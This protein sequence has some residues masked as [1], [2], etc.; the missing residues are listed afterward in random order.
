MTDSVIS[1]MLE[2]PEMLCALSS[3]VTEATDDG[4][5]DLLRLMMKCSCLEVLG[6]W[7]STTT[8]KVYGPLGCCCPLDTTW[9][10]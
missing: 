3:P 1:K 7:S 8:W 6:C 9:E 4:L 10:F 2:S 5:K